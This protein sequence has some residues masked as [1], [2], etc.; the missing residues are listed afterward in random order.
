MIFE[1]DMGNILTFTNFKNALS[2]EMEFLIIRLNYKN[3]PYKSP[4]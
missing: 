3:T 4:S 2:T 1:G